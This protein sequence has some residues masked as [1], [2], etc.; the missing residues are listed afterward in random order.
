M[1][2]KMKKT[3]NKIN[4]NNRDSLLVIVALGNP[5]EEYNKTRHNAGFIFLDKL[6][7]LIDEKWRLDT[8]FRSEIIKRANLFLIKPN[9]FMNNSGQAVEALMSYHKLLP[10]KLLIKTKDSDLSDKLIV[11]HDDL[12]IEFGKYKFSIDSRAAGHN[13]VQ[14]IINHLKTKNFTRLRLGIKT[15][16]LKHVPGKDFVLKRFDSEERAKLG[17][18]IKEIISND[19]I[20]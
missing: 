1:T 16:L 5:G 9:T 10:K 20:L 12:D 11:I 19:F 4:L 2:K 14:S 18:L 17:L 15:D 13:G 6:A 3:E 8:K 7:E